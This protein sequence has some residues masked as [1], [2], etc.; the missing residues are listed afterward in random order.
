MT[1]HEAPGADR[2]PGAGS[3]PATPDESVRGTSSGRR[4]LRW[5]YLVLGIALVWLFAAVTPSPY[6]IERPGPV[7]DA[8]GTVRIAGEET[9]VIVIDGAEVFPTSGSLNVLSVSLFGTPKAHVSWLEAGLALFDP[10]A[11]IVPMNEVFPGGLTADQRS[12]ESAIMMSQSQYRAVA[13]ALH[14]LE[15]PVTEQLSVARVVAEG[16]ADGLLESGDVI[17]E[18]GGAPIH[19]IED[20]RTA[21]AA[22]T[23]APGGIQQ[24]VAIGIL[25]KGTPL[26]VSITPA[27]LEAGGAPLFGIVLS[28]EFEFPFDVELTLGDIGGPSAGLIFALSVY[29]AL[30]PGGLAGDLEVS[31]TGT[32][33]ADGAVGRIGG[34]EQKMWGASRVGTDLFLMPVAN[35][36]DVPASIPGNMRVAPVATLDEAIAA[37]ESAVAGEDPPD[38]ERCLSAGHAAS[39]G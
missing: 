9:P 22:A 36:P 35:C 20:L 8:L 3:G 15:I 13:A 12:Q 30:T 38:L 34:L 5:A 17:Q 4:K 25:R 18:I 24:P 6:A 23:S 21:L 28:Q 39:G 26:S 11:R 37:I 16:P 14:R 1:L 32:I 27:P 2:Q 7:V 33:T 31:G 10:S 19:T 29:D